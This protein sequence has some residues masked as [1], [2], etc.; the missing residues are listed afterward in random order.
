LIRN[1]GR[2]GPNGQW[3]FESPLRIRVKKSGVDTVCS[4]ALPGAEGRA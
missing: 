1:I 3:H 2:V 4:F